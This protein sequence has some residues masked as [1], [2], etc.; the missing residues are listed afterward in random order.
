MI[1]RRAGAAIGLGWTS[2]STGDSGA[3]PALRD[4]PR[5]AANGPISRW[6]SSVLPPAFRIGLRGSCGRRSSAAGM[7]YSAVTPC[8]W[9]PAWRSPWRNPLLK[10]RLHSNMGVA[11]LTRQVSLRRVLAR[12]DQAD[13]SH[14]VCSSGPMDA[15]VSLPERSCCRVL[16]G[17]ALQALQ[18]KK[19]PGRRAGRFGALICGPAGRLPLAPFALRRPKTLYSFQGGRLTRPRP[20]PAEALE[21][22]AS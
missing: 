3:R 11:N 19:A 15:F 13:R 7:P 1:R 12:C 9:P 4:R 14:L 17:D 10:A 20:L 6:I 8:P 5:R 18:R 21:D 16:S 22:S 2:Q